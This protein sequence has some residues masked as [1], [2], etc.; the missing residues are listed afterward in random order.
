MAKWFVRVDDDSSIRFRVV[1]SWVVWFN[2]EEYKEALNEV[3]E[4]WRCM[5]LVLGECT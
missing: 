1:V 2:K 5:S 4:P 3:I